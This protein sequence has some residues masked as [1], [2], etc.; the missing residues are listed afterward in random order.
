MQDLLGGVNVHRRIDPSHQAISSPP[1]VDHEVSFGL[2]GV[3]WH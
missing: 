1:S 2:D 3:S